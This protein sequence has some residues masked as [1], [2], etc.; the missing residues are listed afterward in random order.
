MK[1]LEI[2][3]LYSTSELRNFMEIGVSTWEH[4]RDIL[5]DNFSL[6]YEYE[7]E[8]EGRKTNYRILKKLG[9]YQKPPNRRDKTK[10]DA[11]YAEEIVNVI[12]ED[13]IQTAK[14][15]SRI[16]KS[17]ESIIQFNHTDG[18]IYEYTRLRMRELFGNGKDREGSIGTIKDKFWCR[19]DIEHNIYIPLTQDQI[20][21]FFNYF[22]QER[23]ESWEQEMELLCD[24][25]NGLIDKKDFQNMLGEISFSDFT[26]ARNR[27]KNKYGF[28]PIK[29]PEYIFYENVA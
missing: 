14:N 16:I 18:T 28:Y 13:N 7:V 10:R 21:E 29:V 27:F 23:T 15:V 3:R 4:K 24:F 22:H 20:D 1:E 9:D 12:K 2:G 5:L 26:A 25:H 11:I 6:Y 19:L 8:Y 17:T